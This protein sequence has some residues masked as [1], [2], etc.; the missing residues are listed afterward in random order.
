MEQP[1]LD[2]DDESE[3][4][5]FEAHDTTTVPTTNQNVQQYATGGRENVDDSYVLPT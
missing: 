2:E 5:H 3:L 1:F 4:I